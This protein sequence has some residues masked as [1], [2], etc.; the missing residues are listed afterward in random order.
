MGSL[1][2]TVIG[3]LLLK[4]NENSNQDKWVME[5]MMRDEILGS[6]NIKIENVNWI[7]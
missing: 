3:W 2:C 5:E 4:P 6:Q 7:S 1:I